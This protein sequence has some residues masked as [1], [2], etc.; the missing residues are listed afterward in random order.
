MEVSFPPPLNR[1]RATALIVGRRKKQNRKRKRKQKENTHVQSR[2][3][4]VN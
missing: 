3:L 2:Y 4:H 1:I